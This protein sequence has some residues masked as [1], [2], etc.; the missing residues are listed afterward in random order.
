M[1]LDII[2]K[3]CLVIDKSKALKN[4]RMMKYKAEQNQIIFRPHF[5]TH[6]SSIVADWYRGEGISVITVS[7]V[8]MATYFANM[9]WKDI[10]IAFPLNIREIEDISELSRNISLNVIISNDVHANSLARLIKNNIGV[11]LK[12]DTGY[13]RSGLQISEIG[14]ID[15][16]FNLLETNKKLIFKG[17][18]SHFGNTYHASCKE[19]II[20]LFRNG[21]NELNQLKNKYKSRFPEII[22]SVGDTP[23]SSLI[24]DY[25]G[26]DEIRPG[27]FVYYDLTMLNL[28]VCVEE[29]IAVAIA[30]PVVDI[31]HERNEILIYGGAV[32][33]SKEY[34]TNID[35]NKNF[36]S[37]VRFNEKGWSNSIPGAY[38][39][40]ISQEHGLISID[41][42]KISEFKIGELI[43]ILPVHSCLSA[44]LLRDPIV[45]G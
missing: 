11:F 41:P 23:S 18:L 15:S 7:S 28:G 4:I 8:S 1:T 20:E 10:T 36:G 45:L 3:P 44:D 32:H 5:K 31:Y 39:K 29:Q 2:K 16:I 42:E 37:I 6:Q 19:K 43:G 21:V 40:S 38:V 14:K 34:L 17:F 25:G 35:N 30:C 27:N 12:I 24:D 9:A 26:V 13:H 22:I 33:L